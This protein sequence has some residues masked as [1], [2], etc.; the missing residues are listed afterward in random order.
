MPPIQP[1]PDY[2][3]GSTPLQPQWRD[4]WARILSLLVLA[5]TGLSLA[6]HRGVWPIER[7]ALM[8][9]LPA[10]LGITLAFAPDPPAL[11]SRLAKRMTVAGCAIGTLSG[12]WLALMILAVPMLLALAVAIGSLYEKRRN[13]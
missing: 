12:P 11:I 1:G 5:C 13:A 3:Y 2:P 9:A 4:R 6:L 8:I 10:A 7:V